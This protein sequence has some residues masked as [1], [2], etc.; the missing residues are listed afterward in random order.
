MLDNESYKNRVNM[1]SN[2]LE[3]RISHVNYMKN[4][5]LLKDFI[6]IQEQNV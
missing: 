1:D 4:L 2:L 5:L 3:V 6:L